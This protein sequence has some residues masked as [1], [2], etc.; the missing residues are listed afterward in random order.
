MLL[1]P[2]KPMPHVVR[3]WWKN[4]YTHKRQQLNLAAWNVRTT[5]DSPNSCRPERATAIISNELESANIDIC[6]LSEVRRER[7]GNV[8]EKYHTIYW[9]GGETKEAGVG[10]A[11]SNRLVTTITPILLPISDSIMVLR[12]QLASGD[13]LKIVSVY[14]PTMQR[15]DNEK[16][17]FYESLNQV[18]NSNKSDKLIILGDLNARV[19][20][21]WELWPDVLGKHGTGKMNSNGFI[22]L[23]FCAQNHFSIMGSMFQLPNRLKCTWQHPRSKHWHQLDHIISNTITKSAINV[24]KASLTA[25]CF[26]DHRLVVC[27]CTFPLKKKKKGQKPPIKPSITM[28]QEKIDRLQEYINENLPNCSNTWESFKETLQNA[29]IHT[30]GK[31]KNQNSDWFDENDLEIRT[32][33]KNKH[34]NRQEIQKR[35]RAMKNNWFVTKANEAEAY[36]KEK[37]LGEFYSIIRQV[38]GPRSR[39]TKQIKS[40][41]GKLLTTQDEIKERWIEHFSELLN[42]AVE[43]DNRI[44]DELDTLPVRQDLE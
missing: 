42:I 39:N 5:N 19:G 24:A 31:K 22:L 29:A 21:D 7:T 30:F 14:G 35:I 33:L 40:K 32:L 17:H 26:T 23:E 36:H 8:I 1:Q 28:T 11:I 37:K 6:A 43:T 12:L 38:H 41:Q 4:P 2:S 44:L 3:W 34:L 27:K 15:T 25:D 13:F 18:V 20:S 16:E 10:F 9:S